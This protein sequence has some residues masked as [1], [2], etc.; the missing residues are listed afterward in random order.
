MNHADYSKKLNVKFS[1][2]LLL[3]V[4]GY[5]I[6]QGMAPQPIDEEALLSGRIGLNLLPF[7]SSKTQSIELPVYFEAW[8]ML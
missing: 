7:L 4:L 1:A 3:V 6:W 2:V 8:P 5:S